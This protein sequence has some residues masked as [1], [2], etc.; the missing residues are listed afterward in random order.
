MLDR[1]YVTLL[2]INEFMSDR[3]YDSEKKKEK[4]NLRRIFEIVNQF[5]S[6]KNNMFE[7]LPD[8]ILL[9]IVFFLLLMLTHN[10]Y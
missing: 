8:R 4:T 6:F 10:N 9:N 7:V 1:F 5:K 2:L 3:F